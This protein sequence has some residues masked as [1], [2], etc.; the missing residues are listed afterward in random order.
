M[1]TN[2]WIGPF[3]KAENDWVNDPVVDMDRFPDQATVLGPHMP[4]GEQL[5]IE[6]EVKDDVPEAGDE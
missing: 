2:K 6:R 4:M 1:R 3:C 5:W